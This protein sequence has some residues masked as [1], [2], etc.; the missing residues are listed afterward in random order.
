MTRT[1]AITLL[2]VAL[3]GCA[4]NA[5]QLT[6]AADETRDKGAGAT[7]VEINNRKIDPPASQ[8]LPREVK[9]TD[10][11]GAKSVQSYIG[12]HATSKIS[13]GMRISSGAKVIRFIRAGDIVTMEFSEERLTVHLDARDFI[14]SAACG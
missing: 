7:S 4:Q 6:S 2:S 13:N 12:S 14:T 5:T 10:V 3:I 1:I 9:E 8:Y 11:C